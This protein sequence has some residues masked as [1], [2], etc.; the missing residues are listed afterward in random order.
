[1]DEFIQ[2][3]SLF[4]DIYSQYD[5][6]N[7]FDKCVEKYQNDLSSNT[8]KTKV[9][10]AKDNLKQSNCETN[11]AP[12]AKIVPVF[13]RKRNKPND[14]QKKPKKFIVP[15]K[16]NVDSQMEN[17][18]NKTENEDLK[19]DA[20]NII[21][22]TENYTN[23]QKS[24]K[25]NVNFGATALPSCD[26]TNIDVYHNDSNVIQSQC[27]TNIFN[28]QYL[29]VSDNKKTKPVRKASNLGGFILNSIN[30]L[31]DE[32]ILSQNSTQ[33]SFHSEKS[34]TF[35]S[36]NNSICSVVSLGKTYK[37]MDIKSFT[38]N[39]QQLVTMN[40]EH[41]IPDQDEFIKLFVTQNTQ[42]KRNNVVMSTEFGD[43]GFNV[44]FAN[45]IK[46]FGNDMFICDQLKYSKI[47]ND[48]AVT[49]DMILKMYEEENSL[50]LNK[51]KK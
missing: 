7:D 19:Q 30:L 47:Q 46:E 17:G 22:T 20:Q 15:T 51:M 35:L 49:R 3:S 32:E 31:N 41:K 9:T 43:M 34:L 18:L 39:P 5:E 29:V 8:N 33:E 13:G 45:H 23:S 50:L 28:S 6:K 4:E 36:R 48:S 11:V 25:D 1:M 27:S 12:Q 14:E 21:E 24:L 42:N 38:E 2:D 10:L 40:I 44:F 16:S 26:H 37:D